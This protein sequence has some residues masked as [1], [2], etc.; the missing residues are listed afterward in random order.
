MDVFIKTVAGVLIALVLWLCLQRQ[1][2]DLAL[3]LTLAV[4]VMTG[5]LALKRLAP[6]LTFLRQLEQLGGLQDGILDTLLKT[7]GIGLITELTAMLC[8]DSGNSSMERSVR[9]MGNVTMLLTALPLLQLLMS[10]LQEILR[11]I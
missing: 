8:L 7:A 4:C 10:L 6:V 9:L 2:R 1:E 3:L 11:T 5:I